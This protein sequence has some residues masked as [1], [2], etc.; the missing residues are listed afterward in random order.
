MSCGIIKTKEL[1][2]AEKGRE[3]I[4]AGLAY[5]VTDHKEKQEKML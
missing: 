1:K 4:I 5:H 2:F 3:V